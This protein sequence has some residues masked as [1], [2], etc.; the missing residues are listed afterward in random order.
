MKTRFFFVLAMFVIVLISCNSQEQNLINVEPSY[1][2]NEIL[3]R[4][5][6][7]ANTFKTKDPIFL[8][9]KYNSTNDITFPN[10][11]NL[12]IFYKT[13][14]EWVEINEEPTQ[15]FP[16]GDILFSPNITMPIVESVVVYPALPSLFENYVL[17]IYVIG[18][19]STEQ[20]EKDVAAY[21]EVNLSP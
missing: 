8:E 6:S 10:N 12:K 7:F 16:E 18:K 13:K 15:R 19:M 1:I 14:N 5:A 11:Y 20:G 3:I 9:L 2:N 17:R 21:T 4:V